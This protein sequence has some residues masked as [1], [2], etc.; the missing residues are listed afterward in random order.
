ML[1]S[2][3]KDTALS[4]DQITFNKRRSI[5]S[6]QSA[7][8]TK[9]AFITNQQNFMM[10]HFNLLHSAISDSHKRNNDTK[11]HSHAISNKPMFK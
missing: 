8:G 5:M 1:Q 4:V 9:L 3:L 6:T 7:H 11:H 2:V 10:V